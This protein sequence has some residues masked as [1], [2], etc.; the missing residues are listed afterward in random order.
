MGFV[1]LMWTFPRQSGSGE[2]DGL[3][4][5]DIYKEILRPFGHFLITVFYGDDVR[6]LGERLESVIL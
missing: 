6:L 5:V 4:G 2:V 1:A 3:R